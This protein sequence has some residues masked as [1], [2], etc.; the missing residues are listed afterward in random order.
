M[1]AVTGVFSY[2]GRA[3]AELLLERGETVRSLSRRDA[4]DD[5][6]RS[7]VEF[8]PLRF[9]DGLVEALRGIET[10]YNTYWVRF[11][12]G[13]H[14]FDEAVERTVL[15][16]RSA[17]AAGVRRIVHI[18]VARADE[19]PDLP[20]FA[21]KARIEHW[22][23]G[24]GLAHAVVR[25]TLV[26]GASDI[27]INN[28]AWAVR[29]LPLF[30]VPGDGSYRVQP[31]AVH[32][33]ARICVEAR[34]GET[35]D[36]AGPEVL[37]FDELVAQIREAVRGR[38]RI[39]HAP[40]SVGLAV[41][42]VTNVALRDVVVTRGELDALTRTLLTSPAPALGRERFSTWVAENADSLG[43]HYA[44]ELARNFRGQE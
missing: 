2:T 5:P 40:P 37:R 6:L 35:L 32:D 30:L 28:I 18:S 33:V 36:A 9:D 29:R 31:V 43:R 7:R 27:L 21:G 16:F 14:T 19:A 12:R 39:V 3:I 25:P 13:R 1:N 38:A 11:E 26:F 44:S 34:D 22:L 10:L 4:P 20:Y 15:L 8:A 42:R 24:S 23:S 41:A 17:Q